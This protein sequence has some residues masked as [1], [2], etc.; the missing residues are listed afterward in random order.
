MPA[1][2]KILPSVPMVISRWQGTIAVRVPLSVDLA[3]LTL[4]HPTKV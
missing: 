1:C 4:M 3:N 2:R